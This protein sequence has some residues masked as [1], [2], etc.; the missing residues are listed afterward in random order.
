MAGLAKTL[1]SPWPE[2]MK[3]LNDGIPPFYY[4]EISIRLFL[5]DKR[6]FRDRPFMNEKWQVRL[7]SSIVGRGPVSQ[8]LLVISIYIN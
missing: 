7:G 6:R 1:G 2:N 8:G 3:F 4:Y 5:T